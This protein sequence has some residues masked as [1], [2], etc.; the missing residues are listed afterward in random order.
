[1]YSEGGAQGATSSL[2]VACA[3]I[4]PALEALDKALRPHMGSARKGIDDG[5]SHAPPD[6]LWPALHQFYERLER[7][8]GLVVNRSKT[9]VHSP[10]GNYAGM[11][12]AL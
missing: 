6:V 7:D 1:M 12:Q 2:I 3:A 4:Q 11:P 10:N 8:A 9:Q 5:V